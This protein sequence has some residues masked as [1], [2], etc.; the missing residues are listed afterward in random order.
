M[1]SFRLWG[2]VVHVEF[3]FIAV[4][5]L[6]SVMENADILAYGFFA[7]LLH[8]SAHLIVMVFLNMKVEIIT[9]HSCGI[10]ICPKQTLYSYKKEIIML[11]AGP[12]VNIIAW[13]VI[14]YFSENN[15]LA[16]AQLIPGILNLLP[17]RFLDG[18]GVLC[19]AVSMTKIEFSIAE[20]ILR[21]IFILT[22]IVLVIIAA[23]CFRITNFTYYALMCYL[24]F[25]EFF[26]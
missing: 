18:G 16:Q 9:F 4:C 25:S 17:C 15:T 7:V 24:L 22:P 19:S 8:E 12:F 5:A 3:G 21:I 2:T 11:L 20:R 10:R 23:F 6:L 26:R 1:I 14:S 13:A